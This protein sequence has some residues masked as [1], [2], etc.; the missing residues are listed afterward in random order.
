MLLTAQQKRDWLSIPAQPLSDEFFS[1]IFTD[2]LKSQSGP[3]QLRRLQELFGVQIY[4]EV[5][6]KKT[7]MVFTAEMPL[8]TE[9]LGLVSMDETMKPGEGVKQG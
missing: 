4:P 8:G 1:E 9:F 6:M 2:H 7:E 5:R 3:I